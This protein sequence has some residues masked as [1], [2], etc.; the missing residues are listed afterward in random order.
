MQLRFQ[1]GSRRG[2]ANFPVWHIFRNGFTARNGQ[3]DEGSATCRPVGTYKRGLRASRWQN[4]SG[5]F[6]RIGLRDRVRA[7]TFDGL[8]ETENMT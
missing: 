1:N 2:R 8:L 7:E 3:D 4:I 6:Y 5:V